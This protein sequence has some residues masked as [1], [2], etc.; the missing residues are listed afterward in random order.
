MDVSV[1]QAVSVVIVLALALILVIGGKAMANKNVSS[2]QS[3]TDSMWS[4][5]EN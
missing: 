5:V 2:A 3:K 1:K 4:Q